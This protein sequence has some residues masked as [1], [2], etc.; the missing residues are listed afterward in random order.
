MSGPPCRVPAAGALPLLGATAAEA[1]EKV[2]LSG[3]SGLSRSLATL[4]NDH[5]L[6]YALV[7]VAVLWICGALLGVAIE[8]VLAALGKGTERLEHSE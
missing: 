3:L 8:Q 5:R 4:Y 7:T 6:L 1:G 2:D